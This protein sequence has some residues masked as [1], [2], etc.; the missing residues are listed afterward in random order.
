MSKSTGQHR[1]L[2]PERWAAFS[3]DRQILMIA[4][5]WH[6]AARFVG[7]PDNPPGLRA[8]CERA[9]RLVDLTVEVNE[10][11]GLRRELLRWREL[12]GAIYISASLSPEAHRSALRVLLQLHPAAARQIPHLAE[13]GR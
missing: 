7:D 5:E 12:V 1:Q 13:A 3:L 10:H 2:S 11:S 9:L 8:C 4:N 6:R